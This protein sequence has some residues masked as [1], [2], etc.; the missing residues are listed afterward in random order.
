MPKTIYYLVFIFFKATIDKGAGLFCPCAHLSVHEPQKRGK[1]E[2]Q[3]FCTKNQGKWKSLLCDRK[4]KWCRLKFSEI[5]E[6]GKH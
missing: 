1:R 6:N 2:N 5:R 4:I 3:L